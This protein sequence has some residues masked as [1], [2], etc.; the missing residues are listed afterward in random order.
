MKTFFYL[1]L[2]HLVTGILAHCKYKDKKIQLDLIKSRNI[3]M[4]KSHR[5]DWTVHCVRHKA[6]RDAQTDTQ[7]K[8]NGQTAP[9]ITIGARWD[10]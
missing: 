1:G 4:S 5:W 6:H 2:A 9:F 10:K 7:I 8:A 3:Q